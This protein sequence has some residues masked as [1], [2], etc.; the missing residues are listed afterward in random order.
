MEILLQR[1]A[2]EGIKALKKKCPRCLHN[3]YSAT[4]NI[5]ECVVC[6]YDLTKIEPV[7]AVN[8]I[9]KKEIKNE[10]VK[11]RRK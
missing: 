1:R 10:Y 7:P 9:I 11:G 6:R 8:Y 2:E 4:D 3:T 5:D